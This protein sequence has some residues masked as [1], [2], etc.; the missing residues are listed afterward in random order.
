MSSSLAQPTNKGSNLKKLN[1]QQL[2]FVEAL[3]ADKQFSVVG[4]ARSAGYKN[5]TGAGGRLMQNKDIARHIGK[6]IQQRAAKYKLTAD[7]VLEELMAIG[8]FNPKHLFNDNGTMKNVPELPDEIAAGIASFEVTYI[9]D[10]DTG[11]ELKQIKV[12]FWNKTSALEMLG[13]H[14]G[15]YEQNFGEK[16]KASIDWDR[17]Y[18]KPTDIDPVEAEIAAM[19]AQVNENPQHSLK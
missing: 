19:E 3:L 7:R 13:K 2:L 6:A 12:K 10:H 17:L 5:P 9:T 8:F 14:L 15:L 11:Q 16:P 1:T 18:K 4:A